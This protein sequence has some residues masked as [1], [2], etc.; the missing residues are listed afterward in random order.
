MEQ[1]LEQELWRLRSV[2]YD[3]AEARKRIDE[4]EATQVAEYEATKTT[5]QRAEALAKEAEMERKAKR[6]AIKKHEDLVVEMDA[7]RKINERLATAVERY[8]RH[9]HMAENYDFKVAAEMPQAGRGQ[10]KNWRLSR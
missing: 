5:M 9:E 6:A 10:R 3:L 8:T 7:L 4:L 1:D 2:E